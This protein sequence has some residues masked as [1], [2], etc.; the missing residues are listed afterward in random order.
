MSPSALIFTDN[1][2]INATLS[3]ILSKLGVEVIAVTTNW[4]KAKEVLTTYSPSHVF[5]DY[6]SVNDSEEALKISRFFNAISDSEITFMMP[7]NL[8]ELTH[9]HLLSIFSS[10][11]LS[12]PFTT[13]DVRQIISKE[14]VQY[15]YGVDY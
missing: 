2:I 13:Q 9:D 6:Q 11:I 8:E 5:I 12:T 4:N 14:A 15:F 1:F 10:D 3:D 7:E